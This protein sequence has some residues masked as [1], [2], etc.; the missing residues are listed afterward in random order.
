LNPKDHKIFIENIADQVGLSPEVVKSF[1]SFYYSEVRRNL[2]EMVFP[3]IYVDNLGTFS[4]R[5]KKLEK[6][7]N[8]QKDILGNLKK[9][10]YK[11]YEKHVS[12]KEKIKSLEDALVMVNKMQDDKKTFRKYNRKN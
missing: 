7:I 4:L 11:G 9:M 8:R 12:V 1:I 3:K 5:K 6:A 10:T 2:S